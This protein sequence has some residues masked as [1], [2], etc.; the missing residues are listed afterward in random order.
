[1][2][3]FLLS[4]P[5]SAD[6]AAAERIVADD[7]APGFRSSA[8]FRSLTISVGPLM[9]PSAR[10]GGARLVVEAVFES[11]ATAMEAISAPEFAPIA[12]AVESLGAEIYLF[13]FREL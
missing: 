7:L 11:L 13:E 12:A 4:F 3:R 5:D 2:Y 1:M 9:G 10:E 6:V 8:G